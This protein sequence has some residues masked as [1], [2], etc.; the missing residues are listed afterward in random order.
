MACKCKNQDGTLSDK[1]FG[2]CLK[3]SIAKQV[4]DSRRDPMNG[5]AE[6]IL[7]QVEQRI[8]N[9]MTT[10]QVKFQQEQWDLYKKA[11]LDGLKEGITIARSIHNEDY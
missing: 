6:L 5:F 11:Y 2:D 3:D 9:R 4:E 1:C 7:S 10:L 8:Q